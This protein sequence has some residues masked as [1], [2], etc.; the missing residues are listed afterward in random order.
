MLATQLEARMAKP[1][2]FHGYILPGFSANELAQGRPTIF[3]ST[4]GDQCPPPVNYYTT[5]RGICSNLF[6][7]PVVLL[8]QFLDRNEALSLREEE[9]SGDTPLPAQGLPPLRTLLLG[10]L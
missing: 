6:S 2:N 3:N 4:G 10:S 9:K 5:G 7:R 1:G 8:L